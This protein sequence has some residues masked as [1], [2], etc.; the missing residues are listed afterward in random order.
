MRSSEELAEIATRVR[1]A[2]RNLDILELCDAVLL[3]TPFVA[4]PPPPVVPK[5]ERKVRRYR[6]DDKTRAGSK[7]RMRRMRAKRKAAKTEQA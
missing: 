2:T 3:R 6:N 5:R 4:P 7:E 1:R